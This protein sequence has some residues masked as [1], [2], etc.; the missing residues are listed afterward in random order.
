MQS[1]NEAD[2]PGKLRILAAQ[3]PREARVQFCRMLDTNSP[4][5]P[6]MLNAA[7]A[8]GEG[9]VR[10]LIANAVRGRPDKEK[11]VPSLLSWLETETDEFAKRA[12]ASALGNVD[13]A[14]FRDTPA[15]AIADPKLV[16][17]Y[18][19]V[20]D[21]ICHEL[22]NALLSPRTQILRL[23]AKIEGIGDDEVRGDLSSLLGQLSDAFRNVGNVVEFDAGENHFRLRSVSVCGWLEAMNAEYARKYQPVA[24][25]I[26]SRLGNDGDRIVAS[27]YLLR[28]IFWNLWINAQQAVEGDCRITVRATSDG[29]EVHLL[30]ID[31]GSGFLPE[32]VDVAFYER[33][34][35]NGT[36]R[37][38]G[39][40]EVQDAV[41]RLRGT[42]RLEQLRPRE[43]RVML[44]FPLEVP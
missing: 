17:S 28:I 24:L 4:E 16:E 20:K 6:Q 42:A 37:G 25:T 3:N 12:I 2:A 21:R 7:A 34:S 8:P 36:Y 26:D 41:Q 44:S 18:R 38:R 14:S 27:D 22:R 5:L 35:Q 11:V 32:M 39:L 31:N 13:V 30:L 1:S 10:Q 23:K 40:L 9:R 43:F 15:S 19:Y 33:Y 29:K